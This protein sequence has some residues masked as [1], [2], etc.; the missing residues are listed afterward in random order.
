MIIS[1]ID[2]KATVVKA[3]SVRSNV[4]LDLPILV[5]RNDISLHMA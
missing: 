2:I 1:P 4:E 5:S 3:Q